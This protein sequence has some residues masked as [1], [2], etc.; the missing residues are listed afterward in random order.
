MSKGNISWSFTGKTILIT[1]AS[2]GIGAACANLFAQAGAN[3]FALSRTTGESLHPGVHSL[4]VDVT[5]MDGLKKAAS[6][7]A[8]STGRIDICIANAG[9]ALVEEFASTDVAEWSRLIDINLTGV[10][11]TWQAA[12]PYMGAGGRLIANSSAAGVRAEPDIPAYSATKA[13]IGGLVQSLAILYA[14]R[15]ITVNA[16]APGEIDTELNKAARERVA[17]KRGVSNED[18]VRELLA[19]H[20]PLRRMG[21]PG[22]IAALVAFLAS[23]ESGYI[24]G[25]T[26][27]IDGGQLLV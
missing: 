19:N 16:V 20:I 27:V 7:A 15:Q 18:I 8:A 12:L 5:D 9:A 17:K 26:L 2:R 11:R 25:Q 22:D 1:G 4:R 3:V 13:A 6:A 24:T 23:S 10:M 21:S 14:R